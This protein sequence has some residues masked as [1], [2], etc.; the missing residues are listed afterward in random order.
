MYLFVYLSV[1]LNSTPVFLNILL[2]ALQSLKKLHHPN[3]VKLK[4]VVRENNQLFMVFEFMDSNMYELMKSR[5]VK[6]GGGRRQG[7]QGDVH[8][9]SRSLPGK[10]VW[11]CVGGTTL[12]VS[13]GGIVCLLHKSMACVSAMSA[14]RLGCCV[15]YRTEELTEK[16]K[17]GTGGVYLRPNSL[18]RPRPILTILSLCLFSAFFFFKPTT[19]VFFLFF[20]SSSTRPI[21]EH[22]VRNM[23]FQVMQGLAFMHKNGM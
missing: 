14:V 8:S 1:S 7:N 16:K 17:T 20:F 4:E 6:A 23:T 22:Q 15:C 21:P 5:Y 3:V 11:G 19:P 2:L 13:W 12:R 18:N 9:P 10:D